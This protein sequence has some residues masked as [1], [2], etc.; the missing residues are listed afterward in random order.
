MKLEKT[1]CFCWEYGGSVRTV[2]GEC[3]CKNTAFD[4]IPH[5]HCKRCG[6]IIHD[7]LLYPNQH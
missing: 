7:D 6:G 5:R 4:G 3:G 2:I 1:F